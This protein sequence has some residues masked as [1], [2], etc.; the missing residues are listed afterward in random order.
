MNIGIVI[1]SLEAGGAERVAVNLANSLARTGHSVSLI[2]FDEEG[3]DYYI[4][5]KTVNRVALRLARLSNNLFEALLYNLKKIYKLRN[6]FKTLNQDVVIS[7]TSIISILCIIA[8]IGLKTKIVVREAVYPPAFPLSPVWAALR[9]FIYPF[10]YKIVMQTEAGTSWVKRKIPFASV[11]K[12]PNP[13]RLPLPKIEPVISPESIVLPGRN[14]I[15][16]VGRLSAQKGFD[17]LIRAYKEFYQA[18]PEWDVV[19]I[20][21]GPLKTQLLAMIKQFS[22]VGRVHIIGRVGNIADWYKRA[23]IFVLSSRFEGMPNVLLEAMAH[24]CAVVS[25]NCPSG[26]NEIIINGKN[27][28]LVELEGG[29]HALMTGI[30]RL[31]KNP[32]YRMKLSRE[33]SK[34]VSVLNMERIINNWEQLIKEAYHND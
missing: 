14:I 16:A 10:A 34:I 23:E 29:Y 26:P 12:I 5:D 20:G 1:Y 3:K 25:F 15:L 21:E 33:A 4:V 27:G 17:I 28:I 32:T 9:F 8:A 2:T 31:I 6:T 24:G 22:L 11:V 18:Y 19:I 7:F 30:L 13:V